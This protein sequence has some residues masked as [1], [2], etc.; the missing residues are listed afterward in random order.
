MSL[1]F[2]NNELNKHRL[3]ILN[4]IENGYPLSIYDI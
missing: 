1:I 4:I 2:D 3:E